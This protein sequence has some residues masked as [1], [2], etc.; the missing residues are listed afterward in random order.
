MSDLAALGLG[1]LLLAGNAFFVGAEFALISARRSEIEPRAE[2][3]SRAARVALKAIENV[4]LMMA[5]AQ[6]GITIC[7]LGL[8]RLAEPALHH[9]LEGPL[10]L[11]GIPEAATSAIAFALALLIVS[12]LHI[13]LG[14]MVP[15]NVALARPEASALIYATPLSLVARVLG[16]II[17][18]LNGFANILLRLVGVEPKEEVT[19]SFTRD[20]VSDLVSESHREGLLDDHEGGLLAGALSFTERDASAVLLPLDDLETLP[21]SVTP[22]EVEEVAARTGFSRFPIV[23]DSGEMAGYL[24]LKDALE[25]EDRHRN[26]PIAESWI[27]RLPRVSISDPLRSVMATMRRSGSHLARVTDASGKTLGIAA[28]EDVIEELV[29][30][31]RDEVTSTA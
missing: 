5:C 18:G 24:H 11:T 3:G 14:E 17:R 31:I 27:R 26:R 7:T 2:E 8:G 28:L 25:F 30:E 9:L 22:A 6:L 20:E 13:I 12:L 16:P 10:G 29:G 4:T 19:S 15:K 21:L 23:R 1:V